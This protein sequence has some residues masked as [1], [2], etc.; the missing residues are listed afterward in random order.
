MENSIEIPQK[1]KNRLTY[2]PEIPFLDIYPKKMRTLIQSV[3]C[4]TMFI[5]EL[6]AVVN[7]Q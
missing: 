6:F 4:T 1:I 7:I 3:V 2:D 5:T